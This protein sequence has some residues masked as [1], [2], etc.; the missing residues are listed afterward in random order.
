MLN[1]SEITRET[2]QYAIAGGNPTLINIIKQSGHSFEKCLETSVKYHRYE[3]T[4]WLNENYKCKPLSLATCI[5]YFNIDAFFYLLEHG[6]S[7][8]EIV[9]D[10][11]KTFEESSTFGNL[12]LFQYLYENGTKLGANN[13]QRSI[14]LIASGDG[15]LPIV[16][17]LL[18]QDENIKLVGGDAYSAL[19]R[20][21][22]QPSSYSIFG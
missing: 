12:T 1:E 18:E 8:D 5:Q 19:D 9:K 15:H 4:K 2:L 22:F 11:K 3:L 21:C 6:H 20:A 14:L 10:E 7:L 16:K 17:Y 13:F